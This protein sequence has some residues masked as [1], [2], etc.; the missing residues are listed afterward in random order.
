MTC[1]G[2]SAGPKPRALRIF[3]EMSRPNLRI[4]PDS[5]GRPFMKAI[6]AALVAAL[7]L[8]VVDSQYNDGRYTQVLAQA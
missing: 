7:V 2:V 3:A 8:Y 6:A 5:R 1:C 4:S